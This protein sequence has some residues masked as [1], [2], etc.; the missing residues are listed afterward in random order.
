M[1]L[2]RT[3]LSKEH[4][5][6]PLLA[7]DITPLQNAH[8][9]RGI[10]TYVRGLA[11]QLAEQREI[12]I[13]FWGWEGDRPLLIE[14][15]HRGVWLRRP[16]VPEHRGAWIFAQ[17]AMRRRVQQSQARVIHITDPDALTPLPGRHL[18]TTVYDLIP[19][20]EGIPVRRALAWAGYQIYLR[21]LR[22]VDQVFA[23]SHAT[24]HDVSQL[25]GTPIR[26]IKVAS[27]G[28]DLRMSAEIYTNAGQPYFL[29]IGGPNP[30]KNLALL[31]EAMVLCS[32]L[33]EQ[34]LI[35]GHW[36]A[37]QLIAL[38]QQLNDMGLQGRVRHIGF[39]SDSRLVGLMKGATAVVVPS[40]DE[41][42]GLPL[43]EALAAGAIVLHSRLPVLTEVSAGAALTFGTTGP[44]EL[45][46]CLRRITHD[47]VLR[48]D[49]RRR[50]PH[51]ARQLT[52]TAALRT[53][54]ETYHSALAALT[55][56]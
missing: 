26:S 45:V 31:L 29:F 5:G 24:R 37:R 53:T 54:L 27:P 42:F 32:D 30:N 23:I 44:H 56:R 13:E 8:R 15:P 47:V 50:G 39:V 9:H 21:A 10:G 1:L 48:K 11:V 6:K 14:P 46:E 49:L 33:P 7:F 19:L 34:L 3:Q 12:A 51:R 52:W 16:P 43:G 55:G 41:G 2:S 35:V 17:V 22:S 40:R 38:D 18:M 4:L 28:I 36:L 25:L 20:R